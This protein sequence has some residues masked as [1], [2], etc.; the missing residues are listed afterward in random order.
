[1]GRDCSRTSESA[2]CAQLVRIVGTARIVFGEGPAE[3]LD[4]ALDRLPRRVRPQLLDHQTAHPMPVAIA[5]A[6]VNA[7]VTDNRQAPLLD[8]EVDQHAVAL[9]RPVH[10]ETTEDVAGSRQGVGSA[11]EQTPRHAA[12]EMHPD[13]RR[14]ARLGGLDR[15]GDRVQV[16]LAEERPGPP[17][18]SWHHQP[19]LAPPPPEL[20]PP[21]ENPPSPDEP[22]PPPPHP[23]P[24][25][26][27]ASPQDL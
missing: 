2:R 14:R 13:L 20:P 12:L 24:P 11:A 6:R 15:P 3:L 7:L 5:D 9:G 25:Y 19:P 8:R 23:P 21:P 27:P 22:P 1:M 10:A 16:R 18:V 17:G 26:Q 4:R